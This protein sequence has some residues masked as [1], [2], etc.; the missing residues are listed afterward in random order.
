MKT[1]LALALTLSTLA[2]AGILAA[3]AQAQQPTPPAPPAAA[4]GPS[5]A[6]PAQ[7]GPS[8]MRADHGPGGMN[9]GRG[10]DRFSPEDRAAF[11][12]ARL[13]SI[14]AG[15]RLTPDQEKMWPA[16]ESAVRDMVKQGVEARQQ[17]ET[18]GAPKDPVERMARM[19][20]AAS[21]RGAALTKLADAA[22][23]L[24]SSLAED[25][26]RRLM[27]L[28]HPMRGGEGGRGMMRHEDRHEHR[29]WREHRDDR[30]YMRGRD[31]R[32]GRRFGGDEDRRGRGEDFYRRGMNDSGRM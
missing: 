4:S 18:Q 20:E 25:Q 26:K 16:V 24:Y 23:P 3:G 22:R 29:G 19:G 32:D 8:G 14:H 30:G 6:S 12:E 15:L 21:R 7:P 27:A 11:F 31:D 10:A 2:G 9:M 1:R 17:R 5:P 28:V 13:A